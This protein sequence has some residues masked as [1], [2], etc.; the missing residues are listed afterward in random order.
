MAVFSYMSFSE[1]SMRHPVLQA[2]DERKAMVLL[3]FLPTEGKERLLLLPPPSDTADGFLSQADGRLGQSPSAKVWARGR[4]F[5]ATSAFLAGVFNQIQLCSVFCT[6][7]VI[8]ICGGVPSNHVTV[9]SGLKLCSKIIQS[10]PW[11]QQMPG[12]RARAGAG[13]PVAVAPCPVG[14]FGRRILVCF[15]GTAVRAVSQQLRAQIKQERELGGGHPFQ[16]CWYVHGH[17]YNSGQ[18]LRSSGL[19]PQPWDF[20]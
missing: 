13:A 10:N 7:G 20:Y 6:E 3:F 19:S 11:W 1:G 8:P 2:Q 15:F 17:A 14:G 4:G 9:P 5:C 16:I 12:T 18:F